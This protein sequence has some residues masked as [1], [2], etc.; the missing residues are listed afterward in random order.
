M[1][2]DLS[3]KM[4]ELERIKLGLGKWFLR[5]S[6]CLFPFFVPVR[7]DGHHRSF[8]DFPIFGFPCLNILDCRMI[9]RIFLHFFVNIDDHERPDGIGGRQIADCC[10][11]F[12]KMRR[13]VELSSILICHEFIRAGNESML[14][15][16]KGLPNLTISLVFTTSY[17]RFELGIPK[18]GPDS[19]SRAKCMGQ[20]DIF[21]LFQD[22][23]VDIPKFC[24]CTNCWRYS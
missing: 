11:K 3:L 8:R 17:R 12:V 4:E 7:T 2:K 14:L 5:K 22:L 23:I 21:C 6:F 16:I 20:I 1:K 24:I 18:A 9:S 13:R 15:V 10:A 19:Y